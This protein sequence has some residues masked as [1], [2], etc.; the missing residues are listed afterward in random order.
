MTAVPPGPAGAAVRSRDVVFTF[1]AETWADAR[2]RQLTMPSDRLAAALLE[3]EEVDRVLVAD[4]FRS[5]PVRLAR[6]ALRGPDPG[7]PAGPGPA[8]RSRLVTPAGLRRRD[9]VDVAALRRVY[10]AYDRRLRRAA[11]GLGLRSPAVITTNPFVAAFS[12]L[13]W[14]GPVTYYAWDDWAAHPAHR[15]WWPAYRAAY[16][17]V[18]RRGARACAVSQVLLDRLAPTGPAL[19]VPNAVDPAEW[20]APGAPPAWFA[21]LPGPRLL[22]VGALGDRLDCGAVAEVARRFPGGSIVL[23]GPVADPGPLEPLRALP[24]VRVEPPVPRADV[25]GLVAAADACVMPHRR[26][27][28]TEAMSPLKLYEYVAGGRPVVA[29]DLPPARAVDPRVVLVPAGASFAD[30]VAAALARGPAAEEA[31][32]AFLHANAWSRRH[33]AILGLALA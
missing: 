2:R 31:R 12:P 16:E 8:E 7:F 17:A 23:V 10:A 20:Q 25:V 15:P 18:R 21:A 19:V 32:Q 27:P 9:P 28:L 26:T 4:P 29:T 33:D 14:A 30:S 6:R 11:E 5:L 13:G 22:Y 1:S 24:N 3:R